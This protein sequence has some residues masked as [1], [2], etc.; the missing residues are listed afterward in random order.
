MKKQLLIAGGTGMIGTALQ[1][2]ALANEWEVT[3]LSRR[4]EK[5]VITWDPEKRNIDLPGK[6]EFDAIVNLA[7]A[8]LNKRWTDGNKKEFYDSRINSCR[9]IENYLFDGRISSDVYLGASAIGIYGDRGQ[10]IVNERTP[11]KKDN[12]FTALVMDWEKCHKQIAALELRTIILRFGV[13]LSKEDGALKEI[14]KSTPFGI[15]PQFGNGSQ[16]WSWIHIEDVASIILYCLEQKKMSGAYLA[17]APFPVSNRKLIKSFNA[18]LG[19]LI[20]PVPK[21]M[22]SIM[23]GEMHRVVFDSCNAPPQKI[24]NAG[25]KFRYETIEEAAKALLD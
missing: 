1:R 10:D 4:S 2:Q 8:N 6:M 15:L 3:F 14:L 11:V 20:I 21:L 12:W 9:T 13:V 24:M 23:L 5:N 17:T 22:L 18:H 16:V 7:G 19:K 25:Y